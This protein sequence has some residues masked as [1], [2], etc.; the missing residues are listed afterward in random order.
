MKQVEIK[1][2]R[3]VEEYV[4]ITRTLFL[5][6][7]G[8]LL[9]R[10]MNRVGVSFTSFYSSVVL[11]LFPLLS[12]LV[13][14]YFKNKLYYCKGLK[15]DFYFDGL[16][17]IFCS[18]L[19]PYENESFF[20]FLLFMPVVTSSLQHGVKL[21]FFWA[22]CITLGIIAIDLLSGAGLLDLD[23]LVAGMA[24]LFAYLLGR[25]SETE[26]Q[27][28]EE[29]LRQASID[30]ITG[31]QNHRSFHDLLEEGIRSA[32]V[33]NG[34]LSLL[35]VDIDFF[36]YYNDA[37]GHKK[38]DGVLRKIAQ[39]IK[40]HCSEGVFPAR[41]EGDT[42]GIIVYGDAKEGLTIG[43][44]IRTAVEA[45]DFEGD[46]I[47]PGGH[48]T[49][50]VGVASYP[51]NAQTR[52][53]LIER[54]DDALSKAKYT[55]SNK[56][57]LYYSVFDEIGDSL[58]A[59]DRDLLSSMRTLLMVIN[60][61]DKYTYGHSERVMHYAIQIARKLALWEWEIQDLSMG[62]LLHD[63]GKIELSREILNKTGKLTAREWKL[64]CQHTVWGAD[65]IRPI[66]NMEE[67][68]NIVLYH[69]ENYD[70]SGYPH[71]L[72]GEAIPLGA[73]I[74]R[75]ADSFD[76][77]T[78]KRPYKDSV[79]INAAVRD[80]EKLRGI[81]YDPNVLDAFIEYIYETGIIA[82]KIS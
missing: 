11:T 74:L 7:Y 65:M 75:V 67:V 16:Y 73:R 42:F 21:G 4:L 64:V 60:A 15:I 22:G 46:H 81:H 72:A 25:M 29:I 27:A 33:L 6:L 82:H 26:K 17:L 57:E 44:S 47:L 10:V 2:I 71:G 3:K 48:L 56:V 50:S 28:R 53:S 39:I 13:L 61:K 55:K 24:W 35:L 31:L 63:I 77:M 20:N 54:A 70:G 19:L 5:L 62:A 40:Q 1:R 32:K 9:A 18:I 36:K 34:K 43:E 12:L 52:E 14:M 59:K 58:Q 8:I 23:L 78:T 38:G 66:S 80:M 45:A 41:Y 69:H 68:L 79:T 49:V 51:D 37:Y 30:I 76:A